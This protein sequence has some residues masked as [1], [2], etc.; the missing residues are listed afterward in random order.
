MWFT[1]DFFNFIPNSYNP[2]DKGMVNVE[3]SSDFSKI[4]KFQTDFLQ[5]QKEYGERQSVINKFKERNERPIEKPIENPETRIG[6]NNS[7]TV[8]PEDD[9]YEDF[10]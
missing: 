8:E 10:E 2:N 3:V 7:E 1:G 6:K 4:R 9:N 5:K